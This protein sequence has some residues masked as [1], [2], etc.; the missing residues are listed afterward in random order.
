MVEKTANIPSLSI[1]VL[2]MRSI[3]LCYTEGEGVGVTSRRIQSVFFFFFFKLWWSEFVC[4]CLFNVDVC[5]KMLHISVICLVCFVL[6]TLLLVRRLGPRV[7]A[8]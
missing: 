4:G 8:I 3:S 1:H 2:M 5:L 7:V 6:L